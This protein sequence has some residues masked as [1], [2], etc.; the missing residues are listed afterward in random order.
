MRGIGRDKPRRAMGPACERVWLRDSMTGFR[1]KGSYSLRRPCCTLTAL[2]ATTLIPIWIKEWMPGGV[3]LEVLCK[4]CRTT[5]LKWN[6]EI[7]RRLISRTSREIQA[8]KLGRADRD[9]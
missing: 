6:K 5:V 1:L 9:G 2:D 8:G 7:L 3:R 4:T